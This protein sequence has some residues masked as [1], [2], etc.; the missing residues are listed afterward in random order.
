MTMAT[1]DHTSPPACVPH[2]KL[3]VA[4]LAESML[5]EWP[6]SDGFYPG[7]PDNAV[8]IAEKWLCTLPVSKSGTLHNAP[9]LIDS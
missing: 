4:R 5:L 2:K 6:V 3:I 9:S 1:R 7:R 8:M